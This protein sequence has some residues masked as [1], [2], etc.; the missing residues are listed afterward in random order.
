VL[1]VKLLTNIVKQLSTIFLNRKQL[2]ANTIFKDLKNLVNLVRQLILKFFRQISLQ[3]S[4]LICRAGNFARRPFDSLT[5]LSGLSALTGLYGF[6]DV[7]LGSKCQ[8]HRWVGV[9]GFTLVDA[10]EVEGPEQVREP[11]LDSWV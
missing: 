6:E 1:R 2:K 9:V 5:G 3:L 10:L 7:L 8:V 11:G 4:V